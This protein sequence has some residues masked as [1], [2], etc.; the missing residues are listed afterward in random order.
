MYEKSEHGEMCA[1][2]NHVGWNDHMGGMS[3]GKSV[4]YSVM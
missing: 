1:I 4:Y 2:N 3:M